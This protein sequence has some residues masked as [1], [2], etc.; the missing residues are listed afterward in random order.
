MANTDTAAIAGLVTDA[1]DQAVAM[2]NRHLPLLRNL[3]DK[4][5]VDPT[6]SGDTYTLF[7]YNDLAETS[8]LL[9]ENTDTT[10]VAVPD[11]D[12][13]VIGIKEFGRTIQKTK[14]LDLVSLS[15]IDPIVTSLLARD[16]AVSLDNE[17]STIAYAGTNVVRGGG[18]AATNLVTATDVLTADI[19]RNIVTSLRENAAAPRRGD[20]YAAY[21]HPRVALDLRKET[22]AGG[23]RDDH[24]YTSP[25]LFWAGETGVY[26]GAMFI[27]SAR[28]KV[29]TDGASSAKVYRSLFAG[30]EALAEVVWEPVHTV[31]GEVVDHLKRFRP[32][33]WYGALN[34]GRYRE[35][36]LFRLETGASTGN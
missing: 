11:V 34:W 23:W 35:T 31:I 3:P 1:Y 26:E 4:H 16:E 32:I 8:S 28:M 20:D 5:L 33:S 27:E 17:V 12:P 9:T 7:F 2:K 6:H 36:N 24:K 29:A 25:E 14:K 30:S 19:V 22:G 10:P 18:K 21:V 13:V 15:K